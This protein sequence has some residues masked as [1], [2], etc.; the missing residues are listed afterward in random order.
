MRES[1]GLKDVS[2]VVGGIGGFSGCVSGIVGGIGGFSGSQEEPEGGIGG[3]GVE[4]HDQHGGKV[5]RFE[6]EG[7]RNG[8]I[9]SDSSVDKVGPEDCRTRGTSCCSLSLKSCRHEVIA[10]HMEML[11]FTIED[12]R[13]YCS[14]G[15]QMFA[16]L[17]DFIMLF[18]T[19]VFLLSESGSMFIS[20]HPQHS[21]TVAGRAWTEETNINKTTTTIN[22]STTMFLF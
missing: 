2:A 21:L 18:M 19:I 8:G 20:I 4:F 22:I 12:M 7:D 9:G 6:E 13:K 17:I 16:I 15:S 5:W 14:H 11:K 1:G 3:N 10:S